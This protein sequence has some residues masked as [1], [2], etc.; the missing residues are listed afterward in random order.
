MMIVAPCFDVKRCA[1]PQPLIPHGWRTRKV[2]SAYAYT[3]FVRKLVLVKLEAASK[4]LG[5]LYFSLDY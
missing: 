4:R 3:L 2:P 5:K 1:C